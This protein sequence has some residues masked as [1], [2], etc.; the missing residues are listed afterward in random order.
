MS[1]PFRASN[2][3]NS[4]LGLTDARETSIVGAW[5]DGAE[6]SLMT[7]SNTDWDHILADQKAVLVFQQQE[8]GKDSSHGVLPRPRS[9]NC[10]EG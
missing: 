8:G 10:K 9:V 5:S 3:I 4:K 6:N 7:R 1:K 2:D